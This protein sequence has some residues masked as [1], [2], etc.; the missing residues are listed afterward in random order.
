MHTRKHSGLPPVGTRASRADAHV[1]LP[2]R[3]DL[4]QAKI[5]AA[6]KK[7]GL[8]GAQAAKRFGIS[9]LTSFRWRGPV[10][11]KKRG[12]PAGSENRVAGRVKVD[13]AMVRREVQAQVAKDHSGGSGEGAAYRVARLRGPFRDGDRSTSMPGGLLRE[14]STWRFLSRSPCRV[15]PNGGELQMGVSTEQETK[16]REESS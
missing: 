5:M 14:F 13:L 16:E 7:L 9:M 3:P 10:R 4:E 6:A 8:T 2:G 12:R 11:G 15:G 1:T